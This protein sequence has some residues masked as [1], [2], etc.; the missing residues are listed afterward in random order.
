[1]N[2]AFEKWPDYHRFLMQVL[3]TLA[4]CVLRFPQCLT[5]VTGVR[6]LWLCGFYELLEEAQTYHVIP[7][8]AHEVRPTKDITIQFLSF[9]SWC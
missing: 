6:V 8:L 9:S 5:I 2:G 7:K 4:P 1:M 3:A